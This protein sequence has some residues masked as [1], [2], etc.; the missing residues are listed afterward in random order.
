[1]RCALSGSGNAIEETITAAQ[2]NC[3]KAQ[4]RMDEILPIDSDGYL[5]SKTKRITASSLCRHKRHDRRYGTLDICC[6]E[7]P[8]S[9]NAEALPPHNAQPT[10]K[11]RG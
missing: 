6:V 5:T 1:M 11:D 10:G 3:L 4:R 7:P 2:P 9:S 8:K